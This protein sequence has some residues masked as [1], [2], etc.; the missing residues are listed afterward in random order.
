MSRSKAARSTA[1]AAKRSRDV[2]DDRRRLI[3]AP[4]S[5][6][7]QWRCRPLGTIEILDLQDRNVGQLDGLVID[8][9]EDRPVY[10]A[11]APQRGA[12]EPSQRW[13][14]VP[15]GEAWFDETQRAIRLDA[16][17][18]ER[19][20]FDPAAFEQMTP[21]QAEEYERH[22]LATCCPEVGVHRDGRP[23]YARLSQFTCPTWLRPPA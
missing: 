10:L 23:D 15:V 1:G 5:E 22:V 21:S 13:F 6:F 3:Y 17:K 18:R 20:P 2:S 7:D 11:V 8:R 14:L 4:A 16:G 9:F 19:I 12:N